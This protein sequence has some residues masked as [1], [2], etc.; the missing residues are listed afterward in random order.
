MVEGCI[1]GEGNQEGVLK[2]SGLILAILAENSSKEY[3]RMA[4]ESGGYE[5]FFMKADN[6]CG[7]LF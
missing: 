4:V 2:T 1:L 6:D 3:A 5:D 7:T